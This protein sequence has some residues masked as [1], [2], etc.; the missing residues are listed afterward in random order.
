L[1]AEEATRLIEAGL[2]KLYPNRNSTDSFTRRRQNQWLHIAISFAARVPGATSLLESLADRAQL[3]VGRSNARQLWLHIAGRVLAHA[4]DQALAFRCLERAAKDAE[5]DD[6]PVADRWSILLSCAQISYHHEVELSQDFY[7]RAL[8]AAH[9][10]VG[11]DVAYRLALGADVAKRLAIHP[12]DAQATA[13]LLAGLVEAYRLYVSGDDVDMPF[14]ETVFAVTHLHPIAGAALALRWD[15]LNVRCL[16]DSVIPLAESAAV[17]NYWHPALALWLLNLC[18]D[19]ANISYAML[20]V[21]DHLPLTT[22]EQRLRAAQALGAVA[23]RVAADTP[24]RYRSEALKKVESWAAS[25]GLDQIPAIQDVQGT[26]AFVSSIH[27]VEP[28]QRPAELAEYDLERQTQA[29]EWDAAAQRGDLAAFEEW[30]VKTPFAYNEMLPS[31]E[32]LAQRVGPGQRTAVLD[33]LLKLRMSYDYDQPALATLAHL[34]AEWQ[35]YGPVREWATAN[36]PHY[37]SQHIYLITGERDCS[38]SLR[39]ILYFGAGQFI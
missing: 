26:L 5:I 33:L 14:D 24:L 27:S 29:A 16:D 35:T 17:D 9:Q 38:Q 3:L 19:E 30:R 31:I 11:N 8:E 7:R 12:P 28:R 10:G 34:L 6:L 21:L 13:A 4:G 32:R 25:H 23:R 22:A 20:Q 18:G 39:E 36:L 37:Y 2:S 15:L 1:S